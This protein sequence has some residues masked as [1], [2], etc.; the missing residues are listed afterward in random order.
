MAPRNGGS[1]GE[2]AL[3]TSVLPVF[4]ERADIDAS[5]PSSRAFVSRRASRNRLFKMDEILWR[6]SVVIVSNDDE[7]NKGGDLTGR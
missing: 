4:R 5:A 1:S 6:S 2:P 3:R 7:C